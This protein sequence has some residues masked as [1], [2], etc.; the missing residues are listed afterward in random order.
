MNSAEYRR[1]FEVEDRHW[2][3]VGLHDLVLAAIDRESRRRGRML[4]IF[5]AGCGTGR[6]CQL[7]KAHGHEV[8][9]CDASDEAIN[10]CRERGIETVYKA[11]LNTIDLEADAFDVITS[12]DVLYHAAITDDIAVLRK[13]HGA[14]KPGGLLL[15]NLVAHE[16][17]RS[18]HDIAVHTRE[19]YTRR[20]LIARLAAAG[21]V[22]P[23]AGYRV[24]FPFPAI[25][26]VRYLKRIGGR[27]LSNPQQV[28]SDVSL[29]PAPLNSLL[30]WFMRMENRMGIQRLTPFGTSLFATARKPLKRGK[31]SR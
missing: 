9:G 10:L 21:F 14:L 27:G 15:L 17:L 20:N 3:Y 16:F 5:D 1:M 8:S 24:R 26:A 22:D 23:S 28:L 12:M 7:L 30:I 11:D 31:A 25:A 4:R 13:L 19:R 29:P 18:S 6:L 2:W